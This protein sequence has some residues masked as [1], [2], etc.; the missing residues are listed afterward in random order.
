MLRVVVVKSLVSI[1]LYRLMT[2]PSFINRLPAIGSVVSHLS[3]P[4]VRLQVSRATGTTF[5]R[6]FVHITKKPVLPTTAIMFVFTTIMVVITIFP[7]Q[8][9]TRQVL[10]SSKF[11]TSYIFSLLLA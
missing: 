4:S 8:R 2:H 9:Y 10:P 7:V 5:T 1:S 3:N 6:K 11:P